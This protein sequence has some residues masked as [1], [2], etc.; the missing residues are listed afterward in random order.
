MKVLVYTSL[1]PNHLEPDKGIFIKQRMFHFAKL[2]GCEIKVVAP[3]PYIPPWGWLGKRSLYSRIR[4]YEIM[5]GIEVYHPRYPL[6]PKVGMAAHGF[7][8]FLA[9]RRLL[10]R[11]Y[12]HFPF[13]LIDAHYIYPD[14]FAA[15]LLAASMQKPLVLSARGSDIN[16]FAAFKSIR[17]MIKFALMHADCAVSVCESLKTEM[18]S[19]GIDG[20]RITVVPNGVDTERFYPVEK[21]MARQ[22]LSIPQGV[23]VIVSVGALIPRKAFHLVLNSL[24]DLLGSI[25]DLH[26]FIIGEGPERSSLEQQIR[27][28]NLRGNVTLLGNRPNEALRDWYNAADVFCLAS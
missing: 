15:A 3:V 19:L 16:Q 5:E 26:F 11:I 1:F 25:P 2:D 4:P 9:S 17:P 18:V 20:N 27:R 7:L 21:A 14:G 24:P 22:K 6:I 13:E 12:A 23:R 10:R 8:M 28:M